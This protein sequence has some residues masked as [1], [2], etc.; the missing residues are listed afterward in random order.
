MEKLILIVGTD[1]NADTLTTKKQIVNYLGKRL[2]KTDEETDKEYPFSP[3]Y[4]KKG[5]D[6][7]VEDLQQID[8][9]SK[10]RNCISVVLD[11]N[12]EDWDSYSGKNNMVLATMS[13]F[14]S[15]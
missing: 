10:E 14:P 15:K 5:G 3:I 2:A 11:Y 1:T 13:A 12:A 4:I 6:V 9:I 8:A 7:T